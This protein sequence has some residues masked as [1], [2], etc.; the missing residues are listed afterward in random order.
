MNVI[1]TILDY[2]KS[3]SGGGSSGGG[4][5]SITVDSALSTTSSNPVQNRIVTNAINNKANLTHSHTKADIS[6]LDMNDYVVKSDIEQLV[7]DEHTHNN[8]DTILDKFTLDENNN[9]LFNNEKIEA[10]FDISKVI[11]DNNTSNNTTWSSN[12]INKSIPKTWI[13]TRAEYEQIKDTL[14]NGTIVY[15]TDDEAELN[16]TLDDLKAK[17]HTHNNKDILD[18]LS[19]SDSNKLLFNGK[20]ICKDNIYQ[21][22]TMPAAGAVNIDT[23]VQYIGITNGDYTHNYF[24][25]CTKTNDNTYKW[26]NVKVQSTNDSSASIDDTNVSDSTTYSSTKITNDYY[27]KTN[28]ATDLANKVDTTTFTTHTDN[29]DIH[30]SAVDR[31]KWDNKSDFDGK[32]TSLTDTPTIPTVDVNKEYVDTELTKKVNVADMPTN[33][34]AFTNDN[35]YQTETDVTN[36]LADYAKKIEIPTNVSALTN[37]SNFITNAIDNLV[38]Y[39]TKTETYTQAEVNKLI[40][41]LTGKLSAKIVTELPTDTA[42]ISTSTMYLIEDADTQGTYS[43]YM[44]IDSAWASLGKTTVDLTNYYD[45]TEVDTKLADKADKASI[46]VI[47]TSVSAFTNDSGYLTEHQSLDGYAKTNEIPTVTNDLTNE[48]KANYDLAYTQTHTHSNKELLDNLTTETIAKYDNAVTNTHAHANSDVLNTLSADNVTNWDKAYTD[49][50][51][52]TNKTEL[53]SLTKSKLDEYDNAVTNAHI[54]TNKAV[55]DNFSQA[56][57]GTLLYN[58]EN[59]KGVEL[60]DEVVSKTKVWSSSKIDDTITPIA[61]KA[62]THT[63]QDVID[64]FSEDTTTGDILYNNKGI[65]SKVW[66]GTKSAYEAITTKDSNTTYIVTDEEDTLADYVIDDTV[67]DTNTTWSSQ[68]ISETTKEVYSTDEVKT[69]KIWIDGKPIYRKVLTQTITTTSGTVT[70]S[71]KLNLISDF[72]TSSIDVIISFYGSIKQPWGNIAPISYYNSEEDGIF[73][74]MSKTDNRFVLNTRTIGD[75]I[76]I[77]EY[78]KTTD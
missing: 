66:T 68:K 9:L 67:T 53:D 74:Y 29:A 11:N 14:D 48:L 2:N 10:D 33:V 59:I 34:S 39:Y 27:T 57:D 76:L 23:T 4:G 50:H 37:D 32:Y 71:G 19:V 21:Y 40:G 12:K 54:H 31:T 38:N 42:E 17:S 73:A 5:T 36:T 69:N 44:Y 72:D 35:K 8:K 78:T 25:E 51:T 22:S 16:K 18:S 41:N 75:A 58:N 20:D 63:N 61:E 26:V 13:G 24:Y 70:D 3:K 30:I 46:P 64:K 15:I 45:K 77:V 28:A 43:Q 56:D 6:D 47:P 49:S 55:L 52:H 7:Q 65:G 1:Q 62:H 60:D